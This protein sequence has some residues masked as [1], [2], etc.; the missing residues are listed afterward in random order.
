VYK[1]SDYL[2]L[3]K[4]INHHG[5]ISAFMN[6]ESAPVPSFLIGISQENLTNLT[7]DLIKQLKTY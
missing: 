5:D 3:Q 4:V 2:S 6:F 7:I 1:I